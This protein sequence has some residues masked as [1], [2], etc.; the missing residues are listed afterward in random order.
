MRPLLWIPAVALF[1]SG[2]TAGAPAG[3]GWRMDLG[4]LPSV[5]AL[6]S[7]L[8]ILGAIHAW[9]ALRDER[10]DRENRKGRV[11]ASGLVTR[12]GLLFLAAVCLAGAVLAAWAAAS[13]AR[14]TLAASLLLGAAYVLP[15]IELKRRAGW[16]LAANALGYGGLAFLLGA[17]SGASGSDAGG[18]ARAAAVHAVPYVLGVGAITLCTMLADR[19]GDSS[20][21]QRTSAVVLGEEAGASCAAG[22]ALSCALA[23]FLARDLVPLVWGSIAGVALSLGA[24]RVRGRDAWNRTAVRLQCLFIAVLLPRAWLP[25]VWAL[26]WGGAATLYHRVRFGVT[27]PAVAV[28]GGEE[29]DGVPRGSEAQGRRI[30]AEPSNT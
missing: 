24:A 8:L 19:E 29:R 18:H 22:L 7:L 21:G 9:N 5:G 13:P 4:G 6:F 25:L 11:L 12:R 16:D 3:A 20:S 10:S 14:A 23:G 2:R 17:Q 1:E 26:A 28:F 27:Y 30:N 15:G